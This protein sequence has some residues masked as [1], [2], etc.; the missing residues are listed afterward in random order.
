MVSDLRKKSTSLPISFAQF[1]DY[2]VPFSKVSSKTTIPRNCRNPLSIHCSTTAYM[3]FE[4]H[5]NDSFSLSGY[6]MLNIYKCLC[7]SPY[8][9]SRSCPCYLSSCYLW[10]RFLCK[11]NTECHIIN[12]SI[13]VYLRLTTRRLRNSVTSLLAQLFLP[14]SFVWYK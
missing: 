8:P 12:L 13:L 14:H 6:P 11:F 1:C 10:P 9:Q 7:T 3:I 4:C 5:E 2:S